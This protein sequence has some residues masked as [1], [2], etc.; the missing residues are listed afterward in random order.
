[1]DGECRTEVNEGVTSRFALL[2][3]LSLNFSTS[4]FVIRVILVPLWFIIISLVFFYLR[5]LFFSGKVSF[6]LKVILYLAKITLEN[7]YTVV[8][9][10]PFK[11]NLTFTPAG[12]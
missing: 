6:N 1:M 10:G 8:V 12:L 4:S 7:I 3:K 9:L 5:K 11:L 2:N